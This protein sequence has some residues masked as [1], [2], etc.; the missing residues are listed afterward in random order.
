MSSPINK[1]T[2]EHLA[3]LARI[4]LTEAEEKK[5]LKELEQVLAYFEELNS[6]DTSSVT[7]MSGGTDR[8][9]AFRED[10]ERQ[11]TNQNAGKNAFPEE[12][13]GFLKVPPVF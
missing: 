10:S 8:V 5:F 13:D 9:N 3:S 6:V 12:K 4:E 2:L 1:K 7:P 11:S